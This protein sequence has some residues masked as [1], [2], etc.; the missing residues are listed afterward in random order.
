MHAK[1][2]MEYAE[3]SVVYF[4][5]CQLSQLQAACNFDPAADVVRAFLPAR[6]HQEAP[7][8]LFLRPAAAYKVVPQVTD[9][10]RKAVEQ[11]DLKTGFAV[12]I[13]VEIADC[14]FCSFVVIEDEVV[15]TGD[16]LWF[17]RSPRILL[18]PPTA[19][20]LI[21]YPSNF[22]SMLFT[23]RIRDKFHAH[24]GKDQYNDIKI[25]YGRRCA[26]CG[27]TL[28]RTAYRW[29]GVVDNAYNTCSPSC[30]QRLWNAGYRVFVQLGQILGDDVIDGFVITQ[31][32]ACARGKSRCTVCDFEIED[33]NDEVHRSI[34]P[35][36]AAVRDWVFDTQLGQCDNETSENDWISESEESDDVHNTENEQKSDSDL[37]RNLKGNDSAFTKSISGEQS[38]N[39][40]QVHAKGICSTQS[41]CAT[42][43]SASDSKSTAQFNS[44]EKQETKTSTSSVSGNLPRKSVIGNGSVT[45]DV[46]ESDDYIIQSSEKSMLLLHDPPPVVKVGVDKQDNFVKIANFRDLILACF[47]IEMSSFIRIIVNPTPEFARENP[48]TFAVIQST[49][50]FSWFNSL[51]E[52]D[53]TVG[54]FDG[55]GEHATVDSSVNGV[56][57]EKTCESVEFKHINETVNIG[58]DL[59]KSE[60]ASMPSEGKE[61]H[62]SDKQIT[63]KA[64]EECQPLN[65]TVDGQQV[66]SKVQRG[67]ELKS[68]SNSNDSAMDAHLSAITTNVPQSKIVTKNSGSKNNA[69]IGKHPS[70]N[71]KGSKTSESTVCRE[72]QKIQEDESTPRRDCND[73]SIAHDELKT[74]A[75]NESFVEQTDRVKDQ[76]AMQSVREESLPQLTQRN[77]SPLSAE[78]RTSAESQTAQNSPSDASTPLLLSSQEPRE[79]SKVDDQSA[80]CTKQ[81]KNERNSNLQFTSEA[82][83]TP[84]SPSAN[85]VELNLPLPIESQYSPASVFSKCAATP[86]YPKLISRFQARGPLRHWQFLG[87]FSGSTIFTP[88]SERQSCVPLFDAMLATVRNEN[89]PLMTRIEKDVSQWNDASLRLHLETFSKQSLNTLRDLCASYDAMLHVFKALVKFLHVEPVMD[90]LEVAISSFYR[91]FY[92]TDECSE[93]VSEIKESLQRLIV[94]TEEKRSEPIFGPALHPSLLLRGV[95]DNDAKEIL[96]LLDQVRF[97]V[98]GCFADA[99]NGALK[100]RAC[101]HVSQQ[102]CALCGK[103]ATECARRNSL[104]DDLEHLRCYVTDGFDGGEIPRLRRLFAD[105]DVLVLR[106]LARLQCIVVHAVLVVRAEMATTETGVVLT[107]QISQ[108]EAEI[109]TR[110]RIRWH[111]AEAHDALYPVADTVFLEMEKAIKEEVDILVDEKSYCSQDTNTDEQ[112]KA[113]E[114]VENGSPVEKI[115]PMSD[116][117]NSSS[118][119]VEEQYSEPPATP[120]EKG[121]KNIQ[122]EVCLPNPEASPSAGIDND[123]A[124]GKN[125]NSSA[126][127]TSIEIPAE[128]KKSLASCPS[129][130]LSC[131][132]ENV[133]SG[134]SV[135][136]SSNQN[137]ISTKAELQKEDKKDILDSD[138]QSET[139]LVLD[140]VNLIEDSDT[141]VSQSQSAGETLRASGSEKKSDSDEEGLNIG[142]TSEDMTDDSFGDCK[143]EYGDG[144]NYTND[145]EF[146]FSEESS[147]ESSSSL[148]P[149]QAYLPFIA[150][151]LGPIAQPRTVTRGDYQTLYD[152][153]RGD[154]LGL[155]AEVYGEAGR[156]ALVRCALC[157]QSKLRSA[158]GAISSGLTQ[159]SEVVPVDYVASKDDISSLLELTSSE[160]VAGLVHFSDLTSPRAEALASVVEGAAQC[161][162]RVIA[163]GESDLFGFCEVPIERHALRILLRVA[164]LLRTGA[165]FAHFGSFPG[166]FVFD[167]KLKYDNVFKEL[168]S[169]VLCAI[170]ALCEADNDLKCT[171]TEGEPNAVKDKYIQSIGTLLATVTPL[172]MAGMRVARLACCVLVELCDMID[173][174]ELQHCIHLRVM[175]TPRTH[176]TLQKVLVPRQLSEITPEFINAMLCDLLRE[177]RLYSAR[178]E[179]AFAIK[180]LESH[181]SKLGICN[182]NPL[183]VSQFPFIMSTSD[184]M[185]IRKAKSVAQSLLS[186][187]VSGI[188]KESREC[189]IGTDV[190]F[191]LC[192]SF[193]GM[194]EPRVLAMRLEKQRVVD[195][196]K[197]HR[198]GEHPPVPQF[199]AERLSGVAARRLERKDTQDS[200]LWYI[201]AKKFRENEPLFMRPPHTPLRLGVARL[202]EFPCNVILG[203]LSTVVQRKLYKC[204]HFNREAYGRLQLANKCINHAVKIVSNSSDYHHSPLYLYEK[205][206]QQILFYQ[207]LLCFR[208]SVRNILKME[209]SNLREQLGFVLKEIAEHVDEIENLEFLPTKTIRRI[210]T[211]ILVLMNLSRTPKQPYCAWIEREIA[212]MA[213]NELEFPFSRFDKAPIKDDF[214]YVFHMILISFVK[215]VWLWKFSYNVDWEICKCCGGSGFNSSI[216][217]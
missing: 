212:E 191:E 97:E 195:F 159:S 135:I 214:C 108:E 200:I 17:G 147:D 31:L 215:L 157:D 36:L 21:P 193:Q 72:R 50:G 201:C 57:D 109:E 92:L 125:S 141:D 206:K 91:A 171:V 113:N 202:T 43:F 98:V 114:N 198:A 162:E 187:A 78:H 103:A 23:K 207:H 167:T 210:Q 79:V 49:I 145:N 107:A 66:F 169:L 166:K 129:S 7:H 211:H 77:T 69:T 99:Y 33:E 44:G 148:L 184:I 181:Y 154:I 142:D 10:V 1:T 134:T 104:L 196:F 180:K 19:G 144:F 140:G 14:N 133:E 52:C 192:S 121:D 124:I 62:D 58:N 65:K 71:T 9:S 117:R 213:M 203:S 59:E 5:F 61:E 172:I 25:P 4:H 22:T 29:N 118:R 60:R 158:C 217:F 34:C 204:G 152:A 56:C 18:F 76:P 209:R 165:S 174:A 178:F 80:S 110:M 122:R 6:S 48:F 95:R 112:D 130:L 35:F 173:D 116:G 75:L 90:R 146:T 96:D 168:K 2:Y 81:V 164:A 32:L 111:L 153:L 55:D 45:S 208:D 106:V 26:C 42:P 190:C 163:A 156:D 197:A 38:A 85:L 161:A 12:L 176:V 27:K 46:E 143:I 179:L 183:L 24:V 89:Y 150:R 186:R 131:Q 20:T 127:G 155:C 199:I 40:S 53:D 105:V 15:N 41:T 170:H 63:V 87:A 123:L 94:D 16:P 115:S 73:E 74:T 54:S 28:S 177:E 132:Q 188:E 37:T 175:V 11:F 189:F 139:E 185:T 128:R 93:R 51:K 13:H 67:N 101:A 149:F 136:A 82:S 30:A 83:S 182:M 47:I 120:I 205:R 100:T 137:C 216:L 86:L 84:P 102:E 70:S 119:Q 138:S 8:V 64:V 39:N 151:L 88:K 68:R 194:H 3:R 160:N 126:T